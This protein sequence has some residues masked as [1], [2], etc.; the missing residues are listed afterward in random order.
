MTV[1]VWIQAAGTVLL[2]LVG[3]WFAHNYR[4]QIR[5]KLA[6]RQVESYMRLWGLTALA[7]P[8]RDTP[9]DAA[10]RRQLFDDMSKWYFDDGDGILMST[11]SRD[12]FVVVHTNLGCPLGTVKPSGLA[13]QLAALPPAEAERRRGCALVRQVSLLRT[14]LKSDLAMHVGVN[15]FPELLADDRAFLAS[16]GLSA[17]RRPWRRRA[18]RRPDR[19]AVTPCVCGSCPAK[20]P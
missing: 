14:Q 17:R 12:L 16:C 13:E 11:A 15:Y 5:L 20:T 4:R 3:L 7:S 6:E 10:E 19:T 1:T 9:L 2:G 18:L 8:F